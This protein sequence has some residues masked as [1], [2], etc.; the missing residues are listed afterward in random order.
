MEIPANQ[1]TPQVAV[2]VADLQKASEEFASRVEKPGGFYDLARGLLQKD[3]DLEGCVLILATWNFPRFRW[4][5]SKFDV[6][7]LRVC[8][9]ELKEDFA[10]LAECTIQDIDLDEHRDRIEKIF[11]RL[12]AIEGIEY[13]GAPKIMQLKCPELFVPWDAYI[14]GDKPPTL[15]TNLAIVKDHKWSVREYDSSGSG[16]V[17]FLLDMQER[18]GGVDYPSGTKSLAKAIDEFNFVN[19]TMPLQELENEI[20]FTAARDVILKTL[21]TGRSDAKKLRDV[22]KTAR[23]TGKMAKSALESLVGDG[24][25]VVVTGK[26]KGDT[27]RYCLSDSSHTDNVGTS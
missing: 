17:S 13:T 10:V 16:Y 15:Y 20:A 7:A 26:Y 14:R 12:A 23:L 8:L 2:T 21:P 22:M 4:V 11:A 6:D 5:V 3:C 27:K 19:V 1:T 25:V 24:K 9:E 18:F